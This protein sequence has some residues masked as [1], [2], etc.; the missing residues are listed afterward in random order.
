MPGAGITTD[1]IVGYPGETEVHFKATLRL[2]ED[3]RFDKVHVAAYSPRPGTI[4]FR[5]MADDVPAA[6][7]KERLQAVEEV[8]RGI[9]RSLNEALVGGTQEVLVEGAKEDGRFYGR[10]RNGKLT[11]FA[12]PARIGALVDVRINSAGD[13]SLQGELVANAALLLEV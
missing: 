9:S 2:L 1:V 3:M 7:K 6:V 4:A 10:T 12:G 8:E 5:T 11:H 13:W